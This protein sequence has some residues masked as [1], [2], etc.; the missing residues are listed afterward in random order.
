MEAGNSSRFVI[1]ELVTEG[2]SMRLTGN[3]IHFIQPVYGKNATSTWTDMPFS[4]SVCILR[5][6]I[7]KGR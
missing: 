2:M 1:D 7:E 3:A 5:A 6:K 4:A